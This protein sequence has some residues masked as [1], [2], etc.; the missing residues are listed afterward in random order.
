M[1]TNEGQ[2]INYNHTELDEVVSLMFLNAGFPRILQTISLFQHNSFWA[3]Q[4]SRLL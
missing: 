1:Q 4:A 3:Y 2:L